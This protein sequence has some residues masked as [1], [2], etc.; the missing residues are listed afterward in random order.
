M[1][2]KLFND[3]GCRRVVSGHLTVYEFANDVEYLSYGTDFYAELKAKV[4]PNKLCRRCGRIG[5]YSK[6]HA[7]CSSI[8]ACRLAMLWF[9]QHQDRLAE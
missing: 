8:F 9:S 6:A 2:L 4:T 1:G 5:A 3:G 7:K